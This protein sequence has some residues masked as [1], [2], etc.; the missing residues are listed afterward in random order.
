MNVQDVINIAGIF[1]GGIGVVGIVIW[2]IMVVRSY[3]RHYA[4]TLSLEDMAFAGNGWATTMA[5][6]AAFFVFSSDK[7]YPHLN[8]QIVTLF[9]VTAGLVLLILWIVT[10]YLYL[11]AMRPTYVYL[12][13]H[14]AEKVRQI[15]CEQG[16]VTVANSYPDVFLDD[17]LLGIFAR[18]VQVIVRSQFYS[19]KRKK[20]A[21]ELTN[22]FE[23]FCNLAAEGFECGYSDFLAACQAAPDHLEATRALLLQWP[24]TKESEQLQS[25]LA[26]R[27]LE[28]RDDNDET[29]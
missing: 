28:K 14:D 19:S 13:P 2:V 25:E 6:V 21:R 1:F 29:I 4:G 8:A 20:G 17:A 12:L 7:V 16:I 22:S 27:Y 24:K 15:N 23:V 3:L 11:Q 26:K 9:S 5:F 18:S 10:I